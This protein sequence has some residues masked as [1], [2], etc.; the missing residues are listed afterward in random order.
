M[1]AP[2]ASP[3]LTPDKVYS[4]ILYC[5]KMSWFDRY[6][7][8]S[9]CRYSGGPCISALCSSFSLSIHERDFTVR[10]RVDKWDFQFFFAKIYRQNWRKYLVWNTVSNSYFFQIFFITDHHRK[11]ARL[12]SQYRKSAKYIHF[13]IWQPWLW[14]SLWMYLLCV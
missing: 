4:K 1:L 2:H 9:L 6:S 14:N 12:F 11:C 7:F 5:G 10:L 8:E 13:W 3:H